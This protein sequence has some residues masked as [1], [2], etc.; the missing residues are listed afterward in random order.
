MFKGYV[1]KFLKI[2]DREGRQGDWYYAIRNNSYASILQ[3]T[4]HD[5]RIT[6]PEEFEGYPVEEIYMAKDR[7]TP[8]MGRRGTFPESAEE[9]V[10]PQTL[11]TI[12]NNAFSACINLKKIHIPDSVWYIEDFAF[13]D[14]RSLTEIVLPASLQRIT[15]D[16]FLDC[17]KLEKVSIPDSLTEIANGAFGRCTSLREVKLPSGLVEIGFGAYGGCCNLER[18]TI[19]EESQQFM[20]E[21]GILFTKGK[22][23][24]V[25]Y[26][27]GKKDKEYTVPDTVTGRVSFGG[28][29]NLEKVVF[30]EVMDL[31]LI[32]FGGC[33]NLKEVTLPREVM[34]LER[35]DFEGCVKLKEVILPRNVTGKPCALMFRDCRSLGEIHLPPETKRIYQ[36]AFYGC[37]SLKQVHLPEGVEHT[38]WSAFDHCKNLQSISIG[39]KTDVEKWPES[40]PKLER[41]DLHPDNPY[42]Y[43]ADGVI[44][45]KR[46]NRLLYCLPT[47][48]DDT[49]YVPEHVTSI[50]QYAFN[51]C[52][53]LRKIVLHDKV[54][55]V[56][57]YAFSHCTSLEEIRLPD[58]LTWLNDGAFEYCES[59]KEVR[60]PSKLGKISCFLFAHCT[61]LEEIRI[62]E[63]VKL[64]DSYAF[65]GCS[66][67]K[68]V[69][70]PRSVEEFG[71][72]IFNGCD[73]LTEIVCTGGKRRWTRR[74][75][76]SNGVFPEQVVFSFPAEE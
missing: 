15:F 38:N 73:K 37:D 22:K 31:S 14:C 5:T 43:E 20:T 19:S 55:K 76:M 16:C 74:K 24:Q 36:A 70:I 17:E 58:T 33:E 44:Y 54:E 34:S 49:F 27:L 1:I 30:P 3:Y 66:N 60:L 35:I 65:C 67:L 45:S 61:G 26:P 10:L 40:C 71:V 75:V 28:N 53:N 42:Y 50:G 47:R 41:I 72:C 63:G 39:P 25:I 6:V 9:I 23:E 68:K 62:P 32:G 56:E 29:S 46:E 64:L 18:L 4:G 8:Y 51:N 2:E 21:D 48:K 69:T 13:A 7:V 12:G 57:R 52:I 11:K 59:L